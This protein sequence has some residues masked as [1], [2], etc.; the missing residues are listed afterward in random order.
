MLTDGFHDCGAGSFVPI[1]K[2]AA[3]RAI[4]AM[5]VAGD[6][7]ASRQV[8]VGRDADS[9]ARELAVVRYASGS[10]GQLNRE[11]PAWGA[12]SGQIAIGPIPQQLPGF[13]PRPVLFAQLNRACEGPSV[14]QV[15][16]GTRGVGKSQLVAAYARAKLAADWR[17]VAWIN[18][19][20]SGTMLAG[21][22]AVA[23]A[24]KLSYAGIW[25]DAADAGR[26]VRQ[27]LEVDGDNCLL[28]FDDVHDADMVLPFLPVGSPARVLITTTWQPVADLWTSVSVDVFSE[29][30]SLALLD[31]R[32]GLG[33]T[34]AAMLAANLGYL[35]FALD[36]AA[37]VIVGQ[38]LSYETYLGRLQRTSAEEYSSREKEQ[39]GPHGVAGA[40]LLSL[41]AV[42][43]S[44]ETG[45]CPRM[46][47]IIALLSDAGVRR[48]FLHT[49]G[50]EGVLASDGNRVSAAVVNLAL[51]RLADKSLLSFSLDGRMVTAYHLVSEVI[52][53]RIARR[54]TLTQV[55]LAAA[56][57]VLG[58]HTG[59]SAE[60][61]ERS[62]VMDI[63]RQ[64]M[65][66]LKNLRGN[67]P[68]GDKELARILFRLRFLA[69]Y[70]L[71]ELGGSL[72][73]AIAIGESLTA[74]LERELGPDHPDTLSSRNSLAAAYQAAARVG[75]AIPLFELTLA[76]REEVLGPEHPST[77]TSRNNLATA[78]LAVGRVDEA[79]SLFD[80]ILAAQ[81]EV[82]GPEHPHTLT[83]Q[84]N[85]AAAY[86]A[87]G[88]VG[89]AIP[90]FELILAAREQVLGPDH[91]SILNLRGN[92][93]AAYRDAGEAGKAI[94][95]FEQIL[96]AW[97]RL[98][99]PDHPDTMKARNQLA[100]AY[101]E[102]HQVGKVIPLV[103]Q[104]LAV[105]ERLLG[106]ENPQTLATRNNLAFAYRKAGR[107][108]EAIPLFEQ[109]L[110][111]CERLFGT[112]D[113]R[114]QATRNNLV[115]ASREAGQAE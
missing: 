6:S 10:S 55:G 29:Q 25:R 3:N 17:L 36:Q 30:E 4:T 33:E 44:D 50:R 22:A 1:S 48:D 62:A 42:N 26:A 112:D 8:S 97:E 53:E 86:Q 18:A 90:L 95:L 64:V 27:Q 23:D 70:Y 105:R 61:Y 94:P 76:A 37:A 73:Q 106:A 56:V 82:L 72:Q 87:A 111:A 60:P 110:A 115:L 91:P 107:A 28:V 103:E 45:V 75:E 83:S 74:D 101:R 9:A 21:L 2:G 46:M 69:L 19:E 85:L 54:G 12:A 52:R 108:A 34:G 113:S 32:T 68:N 114:T 71:L 96:V 89:Q 78:Y 47:E 80:Q 92:L 98:L 5:V 99:G 66:L 102:T 49:A 20:N 81:V 39:P 63:P 24:A 59:A 35:P 43:A 77:L 57:S 88:R 51:E 31:G 84:H 13:L 15:V 109:N 7:G 79:I 11:R 104:I 16:T 67:V 58:V 14:V 40:V 38:Q 65:A 41:D 100:N 93:A